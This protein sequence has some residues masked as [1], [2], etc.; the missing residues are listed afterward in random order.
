ML[1]GI[2]EHTLHHNS[3]VSFIAYDG[4]HIITTNDVDRVLNVWCARTGGVLRLTHDLHGEKLVAKALL[5]KIGDVSLVISA[6]FDGTLRVHETDTGKLKHT[7]NDTAHKD[8]TAGVCAQACCR[9]T[10]Q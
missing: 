1:T 8:A 6:E 7:W 5:T 9:H 3:T 4:R 2:C 10:F